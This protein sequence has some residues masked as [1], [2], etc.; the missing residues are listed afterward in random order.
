M[1]ESLIIMAI[2]VSFHLSLK[3][4]ENLT[5]HFCDLCEKE[6]NMKMFKIPIAATFVGQEPCDLMPIEMHLCNECRS[7]IYGTI[8]KI[9]SKEKIKEL[10]GLALVEKMG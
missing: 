3:G 7:K 8:T 2:E 10:H 9:A 5:K 6:C 1:A 4:S